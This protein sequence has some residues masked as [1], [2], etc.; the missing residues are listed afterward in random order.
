MSVKR[1]F[2]FARIGVLIILVITTMLPP[3]SPSLAAPP[4][5]TERDLR[6]QQILD[7]MSAAERIGQLFLISFPGDTALPESD[8]TDLILNYYVGGVVLNADNDNITGYGD[9]ATVPVQVATL[10]NDLQRLAITGNLE[11]REDIPI[12]SV[13]NAIPLFIATNYEGDKYP[14][15]E[16]WNGLSDIP[17]NMAIGATWQPS[18]AETVGNVVGQE[19]SAL[20]VNMLLG[21]TLDVLEEPQLSSNNGLGVRSFG[22][23]PY[24]VGLMG[25]SY[26]SGVHQGSNGRIAVIAKHFPG[27]GS[28]DRPLH[29]EIPTVRKSLDQLTQTELAPFFA[30]TG[31]ASEN[32]A[33]SDGLLSTHI[34][35]QG[36]QGNIRA[37]TNPVSFDAQAL[38]ALLALAPIA[39]WRTNGGIMVSDKLGVNAVERFFDDTAQSFPHRVIAKDAFAAGNDLLYLDQFALGDDNYETELANIKDTI[40]WF[41]ERYASD[42]AFQEQVDTAVLRLLKLKLKLYNDDFTLQNSLVDPNPKQLIDI[43]SANDTTSITVAQDAVTL[44]FPDPEELAERLQRTPSAN[45]KIIIFTDVRAAQQCSDCPQ[46]NLIGVND[47]ADKMVALYGPTGSGQISA[48]QLSSFT[49]AELQTFLDAG[50]TPIIYQ[51][52]PIT[53]TVAPDSTATPENGPTSTPLPTPLPSAEYLIQET[54]PNA[55]WIIFGMVD[56]DGEDAAAIKNFLAQRPDLARDKFIVTFAYNAPYFLDA[57]EISQ[58]TAYYGLFSKLDAFVDVSVRAL[59]QEL[60]II[61]G[62]PVNIDGIGYDLLQRTDPSPNQVIELSLLT[63]SLEAFSEGDNNVS[64]GDTVRLQTGQILDR[65]GNPVPDGTIVQFVQRDLVQGSVNILDKVPTT[66]GVAQ[67]DYLLVAQTEGGQ[68]RIGVE[69][70]DAVVS[71]EVDIRVNSDES[72]GA[73][74]TIINP[75]AVP[76]PTPLPT[77]TP[78]PT[79][80]P[81][82]TNTSA[83]TGTPFDANIEPEELGIRIEL[84]EIGM[85][86][87]VFVGLFLTIGTA[88]LLNRRRQSSPSDVIGWPLWGIIGG[89]LFY[90]YYALNLPGTTLI[91]NWG[92]W[93]GLIST[94]IGGAIGLLTY[95]FKHL[96]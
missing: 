94:L 14:Y 95:Q 62:P 35:Y 72:G 45:D 88:V 54:L 70:G 80:T 16:I 36:F 44:I 91:S 76:S 66:N 41:R 61:G 63:E 89:L 27:Y 50:N 31:D 2:I 69:A 42:V 10:S 40:S 3:V 84:S 39:E 6:A 64:V 37:T 65:N 74:I 96:K 60:P 32:S 67:L 26:I 29:E 87:A 8:V 81:A 30:V 13:G 75:T 17:S 21:P 78:P 9:P 7:G 43:I 73:Q 5:Q 85:L 12:I 28:S 23:D 71:Q 77:E 68:F 58:L 83:P 25:Q 19:L 24:W 4:M 93:A 15:S 33:I 51:T 57:T 92:I 34:R 53:P 52:E 90:I 22:G 11:I 18:Q 59:F 56:Q 46:Q 86:T 79:E 47:I 48:N 20:G 1:P 38:N 49:F 82:P 55:D